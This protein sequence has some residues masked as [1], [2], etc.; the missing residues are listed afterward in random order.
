MPP[1]PGQPR[2]TP[3]ARPGRPGQRQ[4]WRRDGATGATRSASLATPCWPKFST[5]VHSECMRG[6][7]YDAPCGGIGRYARPAV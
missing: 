6:L 2:G 3:S 1:H 4:R 5:D 7:S